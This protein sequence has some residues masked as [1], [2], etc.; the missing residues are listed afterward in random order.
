MCLDM[1]D[2]IKAAELDFD[3][4]KKQMCLAEDDSPVKDY[5]CNVKTDDGL[6]LGVV[7][8]KYEIVQNREAFEFLDNMTADGMKFECAGHFNN[9]RSNYIIG[10]TE[11]IKILDDTYDPY[12]LFM[13]SFDGSGS[14][15]VM[16][17]PIRSICSNTLVIA[18]KRSSNRISVKHSSNVKDN[19][20]IARQTLLHNAE[21]LETLKTNCEELATVKLSKKQYADAVIPA[22]VDKFNLGD[23]DDRKRYKDREEQI[24]TDLLKVYNA[25]DIAN[26]SNTAYKALQ[27]VADYESHYKPVRETDNKALYL[28]RVIGGMALVNAAYQA[29]KAK[30]MPRRRSL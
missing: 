3:V 26:Y 30:T 23:K 13:N 2:V 18:E 25:T 12:I 6:Q 15:K 1:H 27:A 28:Q 8:S 14:V 4:E 10:A 22:V 16:F 9:Y 19:L 21:Y 17:T 11:S 5:Y 20:Y 24:R 7:G 29:I